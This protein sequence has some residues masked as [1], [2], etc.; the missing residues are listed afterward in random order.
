MLVS[1]P[2]QIQGVF[3][4]HVMRLDLQLHRFYDNWM[5]LRCFLLFCL[6]FFNC[7]VFLPV[8]CGELVHVMCHCRRK[9]MT[10][11]VFSAACAK[12]K[13]FSSQKLKMDA[14]CSQNAASTK[15]KSRYDKPTRIFCLSK[16]AF[17][18]A[19]PFLFSDRFYVAIQNFRC[20]YKNG[21]ERRKIYHTAIM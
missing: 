15:N 3:K 20:R 14:Y 18:F 8:P 13:C 9:F 10:C 17:I 6:F 12:V 5:R 16:S 7:R 11:I 21:L 1:W 2:E 19:L 4:K